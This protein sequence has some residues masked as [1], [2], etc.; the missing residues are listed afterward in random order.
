MTQRDRFE[1][2]LKRHPHAH[3]PFFAR[4]AMS[5]RTLLRLAGAGVTASF[6]VPRTWGGE[7]VPWAPVETKNTARHVI[8][9]LLAGAISQIDTFDFKLVEGVTPREF[10]PAETGGILWPAGLMPKLGERLGRIAILRSMRAWALQHSGMQTWV[11]IGRN[12]S[13][14]LGDIAPNIGSIVAVEKEPE[15]QPGQVFPAF[16]A[17]NAQSAVGPGY[18]PS[19]YAPFY[20]EPA[21][22][23][24]SYTTHPLADGASRFDFRYRLLG[25]LD[26]PMRA[27]SPLGR[28]AEDFD[29]YYETAR[30]L[31]YNPQVEQAFSF[32]AEE[33]ARYGS[34]AF[35]NACLVARKVLAA[36]QG[37]R[38]IQIVFGG[39]D[40]HQDIYNTAN[41]GR[42]PRMAKNLDDALAAL[43][44]DLQAS[45]LF[46]ETLLVMTGEFG[47][48]V[49]P[50][51][52][53]GGR[54]HYLQHFVVFAGA[55]V[56]GGKVI[57]VTDPTGAAT[58]EPGWS[59][60]RDARIEDVEATIYSALGINWT[61]VRY[62]DPFGRGFEYV[63]K[64]KDDVYGPIHELWG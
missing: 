42:L 61:N 3:R 16:L 35:G 52:P 59:R 44:D 18:L 34:S 49:G 24:L 25:E 8:F 55:G 62:D 64:S 4:P 26:G 5:R 51:S 19:S 39:W 36:N 60:G 20:V 58:I 46:G 54:D 29:A 32:T 7:V 6:L 17:L 27:G 30:K 37:T 12:P 9:I 53:Q 41:N 22:S 43:L 21:A 56:R 45:G 48:T 11:Q 1:Q 63:P 31:M 13:A 47:R 15:R 23:G 2:Y 33:S 57:G 14:A 28:P 40:H 50:L 38:Y 10:E